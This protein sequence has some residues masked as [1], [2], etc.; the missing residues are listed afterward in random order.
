MV[1]RVMSFNRAQAERVLPTRAMDG[2]ACGV[3]LESARRIY[4]IKAQ[5]WK[6]AQLLQD[7]QGQ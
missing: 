7:F 6:K 4:R 2:L 3:D 1:R 5:C